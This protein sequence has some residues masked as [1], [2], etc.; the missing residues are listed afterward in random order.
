[1]CVVV[2]VCAVMMLMREHGDEAVGH[3]RPT[4]YNAS[5]EKTDGERDGK[6]RKAANIGSPNP[7]IIE[8]LQTI[9]KQRRF[10]IQRERG[11]VEETVSL[12]MCQLVLQMSTTSSM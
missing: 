12:V 3:R 9:Q 6:I 8:M 5:R 2:C 7:Q 4:H 10:Q 11:L 1:M